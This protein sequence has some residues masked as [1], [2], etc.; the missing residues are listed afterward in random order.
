MRCPACSATRRRWRERS[1]GSYTDSN[2]SLIR[3]NV[4][5]PT[6]VLQRKQIRMVFLQLREE[7]VHSYDLLDGSLSA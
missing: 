2:R 5:S 4:E 7:H 3:Q 1:L 6:G